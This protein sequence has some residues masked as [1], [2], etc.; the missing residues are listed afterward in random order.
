M[1]SLYLR[2]PR[3]VTIFLP[4]FIFSLCALWKYP[5]RVDGSVKIF[6]FCNSYVFFLPLSFRGD[7]IDFCNWGF[8][9]GDI[10]VNLV[11]LL[12]RYQF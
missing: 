7:N 5:A 8:R 2:K 1:L 10:L 12:L 11:F 6:A 4:G 9:W 3:R